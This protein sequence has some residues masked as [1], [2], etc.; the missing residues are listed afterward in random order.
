MGTVTT[1]QK[2]EPREVNS[3]L[4]GGSPVRKAYVQWVLEN[5]RKVKVYVNYSG[6]LHMTELNSQKRLQNK[7]PRR[8]GVGN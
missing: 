7:T 3:V 1:D 4:A 5:K 8:K 6:I 2:R